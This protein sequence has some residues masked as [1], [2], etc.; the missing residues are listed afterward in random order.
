[1][2]GA[3]EQKLATLGITLPVAPGP[4]ANYVGSVRT[5]NLLIVSG[6]ICFDA[7]VRRRA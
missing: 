1:M 7:Q 4:V 3:I 5:G 6:Q 2:A